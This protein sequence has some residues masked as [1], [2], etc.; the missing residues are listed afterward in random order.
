M[1]RLLFLL[2]SRRCC[3]ILNSNPT[4][5]KEGTMGGEVVKGKLMETE[6]DGTKEE[7]ISD[8]LPAVPS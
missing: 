7:S 1:K 8:G 6:E 2:R 4:E 3:F 5:R